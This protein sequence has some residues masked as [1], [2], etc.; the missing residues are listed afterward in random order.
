MKRALTRA[1]LA[2]ALSLLFGAQIAGAT[3]PASVAADEP[4]AVSDAVTVTPPAE[5]SG[6]EGVTVLDTAGVFPPADAAS[7]E[8]VSVG[9]A[10]GVFP[11]V[12][13]VVDEPTHVADAVGVFPPANALVDEPTN[14]ADAVTVSPSPF[15]TSPES[16]AVGD[17]VTVSPSPSVTSPE[18]VAVG[19]AVTVNASPVLVVAETAHV[20][21]SVLVEPQLFPTQTSLVAQTE[22]LLAGRSESFTVTVTAGGAPATSGSVTLKDGD[23]VV[24]GP[25][26]VDGTGHATFTVNGLTLGSHTLTASFDGMPLFLSSAGT[27]NVDVYDYALSLS[28]STQTVQ[29]GATATYSLTAALVPGS[30]TGGSTATLA[31]AVSGA[32]AGAT[33]ALSGALALPSLG[34]TTLRVATTATTSVGDA[35]IVASADGGARTAS[36]HLYVNAAPVVSAGGP[37]AVDEG[38][39]FVL[40][41]TVAD[42]DHDTLTAVWDLNGDGTFET[43]GLTASFLGIDGPATAHPVFR[44][45]DN[46]GA[47]ATATATIT[48]NNVAPMARITAP[49][50]GTTITAGTPVTFIGTFTDP[51]TLD[52]QTATWSFGATGFSATHTFTAAGFPTVALTVTDKDGGVG[53]ASIGLIVVNPSAGFVTGGGWIALP[54]GKANFGFNARY[55]G[56]TPTGETEFQAPSVNF[57]STSYR[58]L[59][60]A[61]SSIELEGKGT[62]NG[63]AGYSFR[64][65]A[66]EGSPDKLRMHIWQ[67]LHAS[68]GYD[69]GLLRAL[70]G[71]QIK[72]H[73]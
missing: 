44:A 26:P 69:T 18:S 65:S 45:C 12:S 2:C 11:S 43:P 16:V 13:Q 39:S 33:A 31:L 37:Y 14:V 49:T 25:K 19:D 66:V 5:S 10:V 70:G 72:I 71:G 46:H 21:D 55:S 53:I 58:F 36:A 56:A 64:L 30:S 60:V 32:P 67:T 61:G 9:D 41:G 38:S 23:A 22:P 29:R 4:V 7:G 28:P 40:A 15:V 54:T 73:R 35:T 63:A 6:A 62:L 57:H 42:A 3:D 48:V 17:A 47:C 8:P 68:I 1:L 24:A 27:T 50:D 51:G 34:T 52:T 20:A 59:V